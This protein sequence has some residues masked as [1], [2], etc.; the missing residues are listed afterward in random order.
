MHHE[1]Y[2]EIQGYQVEA[3]ANYTWH[4]ASYGKREGGLALEPDEPAFAEIEGVEYKSGDRW[5]SIILP[6][7]VYSDIANEIKEERE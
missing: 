6:D 2:L 1:F 3:R 7:E 4:E 5:E